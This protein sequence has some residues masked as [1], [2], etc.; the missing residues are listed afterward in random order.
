MVLICSHRC[1]RYKGAVCFCRG[2]GFRAEK[3]VE[4]VLE[5]SILDVFDVVW[6]GTEERCLVFGWTEQEV[7]KGTEEDKHQREERPVHQVTDACSCDD[8]KCRV[9]T[10]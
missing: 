10:F 3:A 7:R 1:G 8:D 9:R 4:E 6:E 5:R 2:G